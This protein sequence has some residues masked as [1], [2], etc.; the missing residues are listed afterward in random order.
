VVRSVS[1]VVTV[2]V[3]TA[4]LAA[5]GGSGSTRPTTPAAIRILTPTAGAV[6]ASTV[7]LHMAVDHAQV[8]AP[9]QAKGIDPTRGYI[10]VLL[11]GKLVG[12]TYSLNQ[13]LS[14]L[15]SGAHIL[16]AEF[17]ATD[18]RPFANSVTATVAFT[19]H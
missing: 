4:I 8:I 18:H 12:I 11:D 5:C 3:A 9:A 16:E 1:V 14:H 13:V 17:V 2:V 19:V 15:T 7:D 6:T 10:H